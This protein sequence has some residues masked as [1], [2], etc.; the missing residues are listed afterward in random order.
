[1]LFA[2]A[3]SGRSFL[4]V[5]ALGA[6]FAG[7][8]PSE[9]SGQACT[10]YVNASDGD[11]AN[12]GTQSAP[13]RSITAAFRDFPAG[14]RTCVAAGE[15]FLGDDSLGVRF[16]EAGKSMVFDL[17]P[18]GGASD[19]ILSEG[20]FEVAI[21]TG[22]ISFVGAAG[23]RLVLGAGRLNTPITAPQLN[24]SLHT[25]ALS[26]GTLDL[27]G[28]PVVMEAS[29]GNPDYLNPLAPL[30]A[31]PPGARVEFGGGELLG[32]PAWATA[33]RT[34]RISGSQATSVYNGPI[35]IGS[36]SLQITAS[37]AVTFPG[38]VATSSPVLIDQPP[39]AATSFAAGLR[40]DQP[41][42][43]SDSILVVSGSG[44]LTIS[45]LL[46]DG[47]D[48]GQGRI[49]L[50]STGTSRIDRISNQ[51]SR[52]AFLAVSGGSL[53]LGSPAETQTIDGVLVDGVL[54]LLGPLRIGA[55]SQGPGF[56]NLGRLD[57]GS[58]DLTLTALVGTARNDGVVEASGGR[59]LIEGDLDI[60]GS[61]PLPSL[62][63]G[64]T[65]G[66]HA[67]HIGGSLVVPGGSAFL[68]AGSSLQ[69][70]GSL[71]GN[72][73]VDL[74]ETDTVRVAESVVLSDADLILGSAPLIVLGDLSIVDSRLPNTAGLIRMEG[75]LAKRLSAPGSTLPS[76]R[77]A[78]GPVTLAGAIQVSGSISFD[79][80]SH[81]ID[82]GAAINISESGTV[83]AGELALLA[84]ALLTIGTT[85][86]GSGPVSLADGSVLDI[87]GGATINGALSLAGTL[88]STGLE[89]NEP[90]LMDGASALEI[91]GLA[92]ISASAS[93]SSL[94]AST[95]ELGA[96]V[97]AGGSL[98]L[99]DG[100]TLSVAGDVVNSDGVFSLP[101]GSLL[102]SGSGLQTAALGAASIGA[103]SVPNSTTQVLLTGDIVLSGGLNLEQGTIELGEATLLEAGGD[104]LVSGARL[105]SHPASSLRMTGSGVRTL[106]PGSNPLGSF[107]VDGPFVS[108]EGS[109]VL[110]GSLLVERGSLSANPGGTLEVAGEV[111][112]SG[113]VLQI[114]A[115]SALETLSTTTLT[116]GNLSLEGRWTAR[117]GINASPGTLDLGRGE[118]LLDAA[119]SPGVNLPTATSLRVLTVSGGVA[120][121][122]SPTRL[123]IIDTLVVETN[124]ELRSSVATL[125]PTRSALVRVDGVVR[126]SGA[127]AA[128]MGSADLRLTGSGLIENL[129]LSLPD[130]DDVLAL[131]TDAGF[132]IGG[133]LD[134][135]LG[136]LDVSASS[137]VFAPDVPQVQ[138]R[139]ASTTGGAAELGRLVTG[140]RGSIGA[141]DLSVHG[142]IRAFYDLVPALAI[143]QIRTLRT[144]A[145]DAINEP[146][147]FGI[148]LPDSVTL[149]G[150]LEIGQGALVRLGRRLDVGGPG[151]LIDVSGRLS[152]LG[153]VYVHGGFVQLQSES[154]TLPSFSFLPPDTVAVTGKGRV[155]D[156]M[157]ESGVARLESE[158]FELVDSLSIASAEV[159][160]SGRVMVSTMANL[161]SGTLEMAPESSLEVASGGRFRS[162]G[163]VRLEDTLSPGGFLILRSGTFLDAPVLPRLRVLSAT[164]AGTI[165]LEHDAQVQNWL[166]HEGGT[167]S[168]NGHSIEIR[169]RWSTQAAPDGAMPRIMGSGAATDSGVSLFG[170]VQ[171]EIDGGFEVVSA[172]FGVSQTNTETTTLITQGA[173]TSLAVRNG[174]TVLQG[175]SLSL[176]GVDLI[177]EGSSTSLLRATDT[178]VSGA[179]APRE[180]DTPGKLLD[181]RFAPPVHDDDFSELVLTGSANGQLDISGGLTVDHLRIDRT[182]SLDGSSAPVT[183]TRRL[184]YGQIEASLIVA[185]NQLVLASGAGILRRGR[186]TIT[187][188]PQFMGPVSV[189]YDL[190]SGRITGHDTGFLAGS[191]LAGPELSAGD[192]G[193][194]VVIAGSQSGGANTV[195]LASNIRLSDRLIVVSGHLDM[196][197]SQVS[198]NQGAT[199]ALYGLDPL[200]SPTLLAGTGGLTSSQSVNLAFSSVGTS[201]FTDDVN[202]P[203]GLPVDTLFVDFGGA[204]SSDKSELILHASRSVGALEVSNEQASVSL[205]LN[206]TTLTVLGGGDVRSGR[207]RSPGLAQLN[208]GEDLNVADGA[209]I[210]GSI[211]S[212]VDGNV[213]IDGDYEGLQLEVGGNLTVAGELAPA[214]ALTFLGNKQSL[215]FEEDLSLQQ[216]TLNQTGANP[217]VS[218]RCFG[219]CPNQLT[220]S[221][222]LQLRRG[223]L[224]T[225]PGS[226]RLTGTGMGF[227]RETNPNELSHIV[228]TVVRDGLA[229]S[230]G[231]LAF[232]V[233]TTTAYAPIELGFS[234]GIL[235]DAEFSISVDSTRSRSITGLP[236]TAGGATETR[237]APWQIASS[238]DFGSSQTVDI[239]AAGT[240][241]GTEMV[242]RWP[243]SPFFPWTGLSGTVDTTA[244]VDGMAG[245]HAQGLTGILSPRGIQLAIAGGTE[246][247]PDRSE[248]RVVNA[249]PST[250]VSVESEGRSLR[251]SLAFG[252]AAI[253]ASFLPESQTDLTPEMRIATNQA[254]WEL[255]FALP[256]STMRGI[257]LASP[258]PALDI[259]ESGPLPLRASDPDNVAIAAFNATREAL[260]IHVEGRSIAASLAPLEWS[261]STEVPATLERLEVRGSGFDS[262]LDL[263][264]ST[265]SGES[266]LLMIASTGPGQLSVVGIREDGSAFDVTT[267]VGTS[268]GPDLPTHFSLTGN[269]PNPFNPSTTIGFDLPRTASVV[270]RVFDVTGRQ[271][272]V[273]E[274]E[275][276]M[277]GFGHTL[278]F[279]GARL[280]SGLYLYRLEASSAGTMETRSGRFVLIK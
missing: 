24:N 206:G 170:G 37:G 220:I 103:L 74:T 110:A 227:L 189:Y 167:V 256:P 272:A 3:R 223:L 244:V 237:S 113:G 63:L 238:I 1:M 198:L 263:P 16:A 143:G 97:I 89:V 114:G 279:N 52:P 91:S 260:R 166:N 147:V 245:I 79:S 208:L 225:G 218:L 39:G 150:G 161:R 163:I 48:P 118:I 185:D 193:E 250:F 102:L 270:L 17:R 149:S 191:I 81:Q 241:T 199:V 155:R 135:R 240:A 6:V 139:L 275:E 232:P 266:I 262:V 129:S 257:A 175:G 53:S 159:R 226:V 187:G 18:F 80:G 94:A 40:F 186:G 201:W 211:F 154:T 156:M 142:E 141:F 164:Q 278:R 128:E 230:Q 130:Q 124:A 109:A 131:G 180:I 38:P 41:E 169:G 107:E 228:G 251:Q 268:A 71:S 72:G 273:S 202:F 261:A 66:I 242:S 252:E 219:S 253:T 10:G 78:E 137:V 58:F 264:L 203:Q 73:T 86:T 176:D 23:T 151:T 233:G 76:L 43:A 29:V 49:L 247:P 184:V 183:V 171:V 214:T 255:P 138:Y 9:S 61:G 30:R 205:N 197:S 55:G 111:E 116:G 157:F 172:G 2:L 4:K 54:T 13:I 207:V 216:M 7:L 95:L 121:L 34:V 174:S 96:L 133:K 182:V 213:V 47:A 178:R 267:S 181:G 82:A 231:P 215:S 258:G 33:P 235:A 271:V 84:D 85:W 239:R 127:A 249:T 69:I 101:Q 93:I 100:S 177:L 28:V 188:F 12:P 46:L 90:V 70:E 243:A 125:R 126:F 259:L 123:E 117:G 280:A 136:T 83:A 8:F 190:G 248:I 57:L 59:L 165:T 146:P 217:E 276:R 19:V 158:G 254:Q 269:Y 168:L 144:S 115:T 122:L 108:V 160:I 98:T 31:A 99:G 51:A 75:P 27:S 50:R 77:L 119:D 26:S 246:R 20:A 234:D 224:L 14:S 148:V 236:T 222:L 22:A 25:F 277:A 229:G 5:V 15:Y 68:T 196:G 87:G 62:T 192:L 105:A 92:R 274:P 200:T 21:G 152:G 210:S 42:S 120:S 44:G 132:S 212:T 60:L 153:R 64:G 88:S 11:D 67:T 36:G 56:N 209:T 32:A 104:V 145:F 173:P 134:L 204:L 35:E 221:Q 65:S 45:E 265:A 195:R 194:L 162:R 112:L 140:I 179:G 106:A